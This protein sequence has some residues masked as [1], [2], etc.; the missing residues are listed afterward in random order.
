M[1][2]TLFFWHFTLTTGKQ[3]TATFWTVKFC[4]SAPTSIILTLFV[5]KTTGE[6]SST[7]LIFVNQFGIRKY[8][9]IQD[10]W[11]DI[12][13]HWLPFTDVL[14]I[15]CKITV[16]KISSRKHCFKTTLIWSHCISAVFYLLF[17]LQVRLIWGPLQCS[18]TCLYNCPAVL[19]WDTN[20]HVLSWK[21]LQT[22]PFLD[23]AFMIF[24]W[25][26]FCQYASVHGLYRFDPASVSDH[27]IWSASM[28]VKTIA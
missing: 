22:A 15:T 7:L 20:G 9:R 18:H 6:A 10:I 12:F 21:N 1:W 5:T 25:W 28:F 16:I 13:T 23:P 14:T 17:W 11:F 26:K 19:W 24:Y 27:C 3:C 2:N 4:I 8:I